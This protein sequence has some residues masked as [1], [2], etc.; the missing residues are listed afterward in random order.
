MGKNKDAAAPAAPQDA[1]Q[2][3]A[4]PPAA[5]AAETPQS[6]PEAARRYRVAW[7]SGLHLR[8]APSMDAAVLAVLPENAEVTAAGEAVPD[9]LPVETGSGRGWVAAAFLREEG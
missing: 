5:E 1:A 2:A 3:V 9:W 6:A 7:P 8:E 4:V